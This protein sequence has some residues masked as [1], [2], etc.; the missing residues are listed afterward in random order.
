[1]PRVARRSGAKGRRWLKGRSAKAESGVRRM[2]RL[3][4][5]GDFAMRGQLIGGGPSPDLGAYHL[6]KSLR[7]VLDDF[8][9]L[10]EYV[11]KGGGFTAVRGEAVSPRLRRDRRRRARAERRQIQRCHSVLA[12][13]SARRAWLRTAV[14]CACGLTSAA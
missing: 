12:R 9:R 8:D 14:V 5:I 3:R 7:R 4:S 13:A 10:C 6:S 2:A 1:M 11:A